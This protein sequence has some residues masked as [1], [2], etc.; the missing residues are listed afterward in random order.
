M[1]RTRRSVGKLALGGLGVASFGIMAL[2]GA[3]AAPAG[4]AATT[5][6]L[7]PA[8][9][10]SHHHGIGAKPHGSTG[11]SSAVGWYSS[12]WSGYAVTPS[13]GAPFTG[14]TSQWTVPAVART[15]N[16]TF[17]AAWAGIDGFSNSSL[18]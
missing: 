1:K 11:G 12:N 2:G 15:R 18:I 16:A 6:L 4:A 10:P 9:W 5:L 13:G 17:S 3:S 8:N 14:I 7:R